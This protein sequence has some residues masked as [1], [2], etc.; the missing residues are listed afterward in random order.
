[1]R[2][3][4]GVRPSDRDRSGV[5]N[6]LVNRLDPICRST[7]LADQQGSVHCARETRGIGNSLVELFL[8]DRLLAV[9]FQLPQKI[10]ERTTVRP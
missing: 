8:C 1:M 4:T 7:Q 3:F 10:W 9:S 5:R 2:D 6:G